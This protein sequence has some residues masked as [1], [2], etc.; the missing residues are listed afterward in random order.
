MSISV[1]N[2]M[3]AAADMPLLVLIN[4]ILSVMFMNV[5]VVYACARTY[6]L[7]VFPC[8]SSGECWRWQ[9]SSRRPSSRL[10]DLRPVPIL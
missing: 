10:C 8:I 5:F 2:F 9:F 7:L 6:Q 3:L 4:G 1:I